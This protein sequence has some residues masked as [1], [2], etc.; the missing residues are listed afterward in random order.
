MEGQVQTYYFL[1][2]LPRFFK[3]IFIVVKCTL[4]KIDHFDHFKVYHS[5]AWVAQCCTTITIT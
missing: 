2:V 3:I 4:Q 5:V 1:F